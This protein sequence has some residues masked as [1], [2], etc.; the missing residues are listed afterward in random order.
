MADGVPLWIPPVWIDDQQR[1]RTNHTH[2][3]TLD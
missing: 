1:P 2:Q 3:P